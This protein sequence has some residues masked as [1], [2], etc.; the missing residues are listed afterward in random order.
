MDVQVRRLASVCGSLESVSEINMKSTTS[1]TARLSRI[2]SEISDV[3]FEER[4]GL[5][6]EYGFEDEAFPWPFDGELETLI[7]GEDE[8]CLVQ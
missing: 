8:L 5:D 4:Y 1:S 2:G 7:T 6:L 3:Q